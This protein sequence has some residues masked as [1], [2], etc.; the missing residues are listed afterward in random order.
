MTTDDQSFPSIAQVSAWLTERHNAE[1]RDLMS[2]TGGFWSSAFAYRVGAQELVLRLSDMA[3]GFAI[4]AA[5]M[6]FNSPGL[7][8][9]KVIATGKALG[10]NYAISERHYGRFIETTAAE[11]GPAVGRLL[12]ALL[13]K[14]RAV[15]TSADDPVSWH[16]PAGS[17][18]LSWRD[19]VAGGLVDN[20]D[21][22]VRGWRVK[23]AED[24]TIDQLFRTCEARIH[25]LLPRCPDRRDL[26]HGDL[27][28][29]NVLVAEDVSQVTAV[30]SWKCSA[31]GDFLYDV[32]WCT[33]WRDWHPGIAASRIWERTLDAQDLTEADLVD[34][35]L[36]HHCY[37]LQIGTSHLGW[38][39]WTGNQEDLKA[40][41]R[42]L[43]RT[44]AQ[45]PRTIT[46][47][48]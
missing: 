36:R 25:E 26:I 44:L 17:A 24:P 7:P 5:A 14:M 10:L 46:R 9:P 33:F 18:N 43:E 13:A 35:S 6:R 34:A 23:L 42:V 38:N 40:V 3:E 32:A 16:D 47:S 37:E 31:Y 30:F 1:I 22:Q 27:L 41:A 2:L 11:E 48:D 4:D 28:H 45:G 12:A 19:W 15:P 20:P 8:V 21:G 29:Q 39:A